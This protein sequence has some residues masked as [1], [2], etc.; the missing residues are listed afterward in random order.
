MHFY[1]VALKEKYQ[2]TYFVSPAVQTVSLSGC[3]TTRRSQRDR[4]A[5]RGI[6]N[7]E[8]V[9]A[10]GMDSFSC[11]LC[12]F[13]RKLRPPRKS[14]PP[15]TTQARNPPRWIN[16]ARTPLAFE[17]GRVGRSRLEQD[18]LNRSFLLLLQFNLM[19]RSSGL[20]LR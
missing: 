2:L 4:K 5:C 11:R 7:S 3:A 17:F 20:V 9:G 12:T 8:D 1:V 18:P 6:I 14:F 15:V 10:L 13:I 19:R 16:P